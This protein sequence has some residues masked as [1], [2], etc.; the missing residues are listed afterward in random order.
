M[1]DDPKP[2]LTDPA[3]LAAA[4]EELAAAMEQQAIF[5]RGGTALAGAPYPEFLFRRTGETLKAAAA[6]LSQGARPQ[7]PPLPEARSK[8]AEAAK[9]PQQ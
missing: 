1:I 8:G 3:V 2:D 7:A 6:L 5:A 9:R 4:C